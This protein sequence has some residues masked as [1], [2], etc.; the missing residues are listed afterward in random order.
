MLKMI[1]LRLVQE[2]ESVIKRS[3]DKASFCFSE[4]AVVIRPAFVS[5]RQKGKPISINQK[6]RTASEV[7]RE[8]YLQLFVSPLRCDYATVSMGSE[9]CQR[10]CMDSD[11]PKYIHVLMSN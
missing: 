7:F 11:K 8:G 9:T 1:D 6:A 5:E 3:D 2:M 4:R 10:R